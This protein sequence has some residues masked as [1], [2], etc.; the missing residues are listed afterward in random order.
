MPLV[1]HCDYLCAL[2]RVSWRLTFTGAAR[3]GDSVR[4]DACWRRAREASHGRGDSQAHCS[5]VLL[6]YHNDCVFFCYG[7]MR[8]PHS[9]TCVRYFCKV[10]N[11]AWF[12]VGSKKVGL[13]WRGV[14]VTTYCNALLKLLF[15][16]ITVYA[17]YG[18][19]LIIANQIQPQAVLSQSFL[20]ITFRSAS[21][22]FTLTSALSLTTS[23]HSLP[24]AY[25]C[26]SLPC[27]LPHLLIMLMASYHIPFYSLFICSS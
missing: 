13:G 3:A 25:I 4:T 20:L 26:L 9:L 1:F 21:F 11:S 16:F 12:D 14:H 17:F 2:I 8:C 23:T 10:K 24:L 19:G 5:A 6:F 15:S 7:L 27:T 18:H 22:P